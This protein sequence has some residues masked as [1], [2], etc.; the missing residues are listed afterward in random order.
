M[1]IVISFLIALSTA[2]LSHA[3]S[4]NCTKAST[5]NEIA[6]CSDP[7]LSTLDEVMAATYKQTRGV[8][9]DANKLKNEQINWIK[10]IATCDGNT[11]CLIGAYRDRIRVLD[12]VDGILSVL[13]DP[14]KERISQ[15]NARE[16]QLDV[17][18]RNLNARVA[19]L[20]EE[21]KS[22]AP[23]KQKEAIILLFNN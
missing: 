10:S 9:P 13:D 7:E 19:K 3:A 17:R 14:L 12:Y 21:A 6:I 8:V 11:S 22:V 1:H 15:L 16:E 18:E 23:K 2:S 5:K 4:F 20:D